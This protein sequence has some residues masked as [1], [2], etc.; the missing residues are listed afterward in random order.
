MDWTVKDEHKKMWTQTDKQNNY[1][2]YFLTSDDFCPFDWDLNQTQLY[3]RKTTIGGGGGGVA[4][5]G[6]GLFHMQEAGL[7]LGNLELNA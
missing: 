5:P 7:L 6:G 3:G 1:H 4:V 2:A